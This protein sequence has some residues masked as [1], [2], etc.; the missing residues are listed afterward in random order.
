MA[1]LFDDLP[2]VGSGKVRPEGRARFREPSR[3]Q[4]SLQACDLDSLIDADHPARMIW[5][6]ASQVDMSGFEAEVRVRE[7]TPGM[8]QTSPHLLLA[9]WL[10][11]CVD[12][13]GSA[14]ALARA[15]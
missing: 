15:C 6:Y 12:G 9:L 5:A 8:A 3:D 2:Q 11:G 13:I 14:R 1:E 7:G 4:V 10:Y